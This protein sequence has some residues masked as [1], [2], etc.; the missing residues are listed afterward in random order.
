M[1]DV[2]RFANKDSDLRDRVLERLGGHVD[3]GVVEV[4]KHLAKG[5]V[6]A[7]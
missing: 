5:I 6:I 3:R 2:V 4:G 7:R 1:A